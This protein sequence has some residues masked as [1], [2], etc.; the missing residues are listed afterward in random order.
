MREERGSR[1]IVGG[2]R[3]GRGVIKSAVASARVLS[4]GS[5]T[6]AR[7]DKHASRG[8]RLRASG[9]PRP[10]ATRAAATDSVR[11]TCRTYLTCRTRSSR[12]YRT[13]SF[14]SNRAT[15][16][17]LAPSLNSDL[18]MR[19]VLT[20][21]CAASIW[22]TRD[23]LEPRRSAAS[24]CVSPRCSRRCRRPVARA[25]LTSTNRRSSVDSARKSP[26][27]PTVQPARSSV[28]RLSGRTTSSLR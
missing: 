23:W 5:P 4:P 10:G 26:A 11:R 17:G 2:G 28:R 9:A 19:S 3:F 20:V 22:A 12:T 7:R 16:A 27:S 8:T 15:S 21:R 24:S 6:R 14:Q 13:R 25:S 1:E 18:S